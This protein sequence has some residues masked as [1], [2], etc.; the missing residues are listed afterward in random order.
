MKKQE[1]DEILMLDKKKNKESD[2]SLVSAEPKKKLVLFEDKPQDVEMPEELVQKKLEEVM[3]SQKPQRKKKSTIVSLVLLAINIIFMVIIVRGLVAGI[4][5]QNVFD[6]I[7]HQGNKLWWLLGGVGCYIVY[8]FAQTL[9][10]H[11]LIRKTTG[12]SKWK[13][14]YNVGIIGKYYDNVTPFAVGGQPMQIVTLSKSGISP[15]VSTSLPLIKMIINSMVSTIIALLFFVFGLPRIPMVGGLYDFLLV[16]LEILGIIGLIITLLGVLFMM[17]I[18][19][20]GLFTRSLV[21]G[22]VK[23]GYKMKLVKNYRATLK[24]WLTQVGEY[25]SS[26]TYLAKNK[27]LLLKMIL[28]SALETLSYACISF[29]VVMAFA[30]NI[31]IS[32]MLLLFTCV[33]KYYICAMAG[34]YIPLPGATGLMEIAFISLYSMYVGDAIVWALLAWRILSYYLILVH[35]FIQEVVNI[36]RGMAKSRKLKKEGE[37]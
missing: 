32:P 2:D 22:V 19:S 18:S 17:L 23:L 21:S 4:G 9:M 30:D 26:M 10:F 13:L 8:I 14:A 3:S 12:E 20:G 1:N 35:G 28:F 24:K 36:S 31:Q 37:I 27:L 11:A 29:F 6:Y 5:D 25:S 16:V 34:S 7:K 15:G 33:V